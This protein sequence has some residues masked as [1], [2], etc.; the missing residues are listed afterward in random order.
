MSA[1]PWDLATPRLYL[2]TRHFW[3]WYATN[4]LELPAQDVS[5]Q[6]GHKDG[7]K[8]VAQLYGHREEKVARRRIR[9][10]HDAAGQVR[11]LRLVPN[12]SSS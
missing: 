8:L 3:G 4:I 10:A 6:L 9:E 12:E 2:A 5:I 1:P 7:G 11:P